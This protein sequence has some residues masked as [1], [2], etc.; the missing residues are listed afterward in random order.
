MM[1]PG[2][3]LELDSRLNIRFLNQA[4]QKVLG[5]RQPMP[6]QAP[7]PFL[8]TLTPASRNQARD[9]LRGI[10]NV[11]GNDSTQTELH[12]QGTGKQPVVLLVNISAR[13]SL[14]SERG[15]Y[16]SAMDLNPL[17]DSAVS[18]D[19]IFHTHYHM[20]PRVREV[21]E[22]MI[23]GL[24]IN[25]IADRLGIADNT[26]KVHIHTIYMTTGTKNRKELFALLREYQQ[27]SFGYGSYLHSLLA[28]VIQP[29]RS[30]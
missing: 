20:S 22:L 29:E 12:V 11:A 2:I 18:P 5:C 30:H 17:L 27:R 21:F 26:V 6:G 9:F 8:E 15:L 4:G 7:V 10:L 16:L 28:G 13:G 23:R 19:D 1:V 24:S 25:D 3:M 14:G